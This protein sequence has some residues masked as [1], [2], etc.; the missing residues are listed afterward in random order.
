MNFE[1]S[2]RKD[3]FSDGTPFSGRPVD[4]NSMS[5]DELIEL[6][7]FLQSKS[8]ETAK[9]HHN[10]SAGNIHAKEQN[11]PWRR[12][13]AIQI[14]NENAKAL[15]EQQEKRVWGLATQT[16]K[17]LMHSLN[18]NY[19]VAELSTKLRLAQSQRIREQNGEELSSKDISAAALL[20]AAEQ[21]DMR[22]VATILGIS[23]KVTMEDI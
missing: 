15:T 3:V 22:R 2:G 18:I 23:A 9:V 21:Y 10:P 12:D 16:H 6:Q 13:P 19:G 1:P 11:C 14:A 7:K 8:P 20:V 17:G 4:L 5:K